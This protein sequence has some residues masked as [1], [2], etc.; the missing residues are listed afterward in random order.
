MEGS[1][2]RLWFGDRA[3]LLRSRKIDVLQVSSQRYGCDFTDRNLS[4]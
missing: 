2:L 3:L 4:F 1:H